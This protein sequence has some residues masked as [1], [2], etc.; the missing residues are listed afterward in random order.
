MPSDVLC[1]SLSEVPEGELRS[2]FLTVGLADRTVRIISLDPSDCLAPLRYVHLYSK[3]C[4]P[5]LSMQALPSDP[6]SLM[7]METPGEET[8]TSSIIHLNIGLSNGCLL[9]TTLDQVTGD[10]T[11]NRTRYLGTKP[12]KLFRVK[13]QKRDAVLI[14]SCFSYYTIF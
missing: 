6:E 11:D 9:R 1:M 12:V 14:F 10:L 3:S 4:Y 13:I 7:V 2:R 8:G 5:H